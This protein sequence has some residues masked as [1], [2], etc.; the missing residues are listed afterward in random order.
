M[1]KPLLVYC[2]DAYCGW[3]YGFS[4]GVKKITADYQ[5]ILDTE[6]LSGGLILPAQPKPL[7]IL[8]PFLHASY[9]DIE[10]T[11]GVK[12]G[13]DYLWHIEN[14]DDTDW[15]PDSRKAAI[16]LCIFKEYYPDRQVEFATDLSY[17][18]YF[19]GRDL[20]DNEAYRHLLSKYHLPETDFYEKLK[21]KEYA[22]KAEAEF[23]LVKQFRV[24]GF[25]AVFIQTGDSRFHAVAIGYT[26]YETLKK[27][28]EDV[29]HS[30]TIFSSC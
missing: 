1:M 21:A 8:A 14:P 29:L 25:P 16:A 11:T 28:I 26:P 2:Y 10:T 27:N 7:S 18:L 19:E 6:V 17:S 5:N 4:N 23:A 30:M 15:Y 24:S 22:E 12:F 20:T 13:N 9:Q 3:C